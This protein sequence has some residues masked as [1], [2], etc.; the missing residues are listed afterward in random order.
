[1]PFSGCGIIVASVVRLRFTFYQYGLNW[2][3][4][5]N[6]SATYS[7]RCELILL[8]KIDV[9][10][11]VVLFIKTAVQWQNWKTSNAFTEASLRTLVILPVLIS[12]QERCGTSL[13]LILR[14]ID[15]VFAFIEGFACA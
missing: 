9:I 8:L 14:S 12:E 2:R 1:M 4:F 10:I 11:A 7:D 13:A 6:R 3:I 15:I 5:F